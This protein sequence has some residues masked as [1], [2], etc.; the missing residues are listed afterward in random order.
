MDAYKKID[1]KFKH[2]DKMIEFNQTVKKLQAM[3]YDVTIHKLYGTFFIGLG[4][5]SISLRS[6]KEIYDVVPATT[7][8]L[9]HYE[10]LSKTELFLRTNVSIV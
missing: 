1:E 5:T 10:A 3:R 2:L 6:I 7:W 4:R 8:M 9:G